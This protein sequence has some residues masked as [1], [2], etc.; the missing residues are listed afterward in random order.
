MNR[1]LIKWWGDVAFTKTKKKKIG[2]ENLY[3]VSP[4]TVTGRMT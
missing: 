1:V 3:A 2:F 4:G